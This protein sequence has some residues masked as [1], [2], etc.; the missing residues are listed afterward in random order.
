MP[1]PNEKPS[2]P[3]ADGGLGEE[4]EQCATC[5]AT[6]PNDEWCPIVTETDAE[7]DLVIRS[8]CDEACKNAWTK[9]SGD[10]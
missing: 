2:Q 8:F 10:P 1:D 3:V 4:F 6:L 7:G 5:G 9:Q